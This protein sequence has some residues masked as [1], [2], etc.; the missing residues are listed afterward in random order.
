M[1]K[2]S[3]LATQ[4]ILKCCSIIAFIV[5]IYA[6]L[7][8]GQAMI[9]TDTSTSNRLFNSI[10]SSKSL[11]PDSWNYNNGEIIY[12]R[13]TLMPVIM[14]A[15]IPS[16]ILSRVVS[17]AIVLIIG[18]WGLIWIS[19][20][21]FNDYS[22]IVSIPVLLLFASS[23]NYRNMIF[24]ESAYTS[25]LFAF[26]FCFGMA[27]K[28]LINKENRIAYR[29]VH[30]ALLFL[31]MLCGIRSL[32]EYLLPLIVS[33]GT[34]Y[35]YQL[36]KHNRINV[37][38][39]NLIIYII[40]PA[41][42]GYACYKYVYINNEIHMY[43]TRASAID[44]SITGAEI[45]YNLKTTFINLFTIFGFGLKGNL[46]KNGLAIIIAI[47]V[48][49][50]FPVLQLIDYKKVKAEEMAYTLFAFIHNIIILIVVILSSKLY[51]RYLITCIF[52][53]T[54]ISA[55]YIYRHIFTRNNT[56]SLVLSILFLAV[57]IIY[58]VNLYSSTVG[59]KEKVEAQKE[60]CQK[61]IDKGITKVYAS[62][63]I[64][65]P[66][67]V[68][69]ENKLTAGA[70]TIKPRLLQKYYPLADDKA[71]EKKEGRSCILMTQAEAEKCHNA[72][73]VMCGTQTEDFLIKDAYVSDNGNFYYTDL[74]AYVFDEDVGEKLADGFRDG[75]LDIK[76]MD[77]NWYGTMT[78][79]T[80]ILEENGLIH[81][82]YSYLGKGHY[83]VKIEGKNLVGCN[84]AVISEISQE[85]ISFSTASVEDD[86]IELD[87]VLSTGIEDLQIYLSNTTPDTKVEF[88]D[89][90]VDKL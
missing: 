47:S 10:I 79:D 56:I 18:C 67:E 22:Y 61:L 75:L 29:V 1:N 27:Y 69:S 4:R 21:L 34:I 5:A 63:W 7:T 23:I 31:M 60:E 74:V 51:E 20:R 90:K 16:A 88:Y 58:G 80:I 38:I 87:L 57:T 25:Q 52:V 55:N 86:C 48:F 68:Y 85:S 13:E 65:Y 14:Q 59:W 71:F 72:V 36:K 49:I 77:F 46:L 8:I 41:I 3:E 73:F 83:S 15:L 66:H 39:K 53:A 26:T 24:Y 43:S 44:F 82:P 42:L 45:L 9:H 62:N 19:R 54:I 76:D 40:I 11:F 81:G 2:F 35:V 17:A 64:A 12:F 33:L 6:T 84:C 70:I 32:A 50:V 78:E 37:S 89:I 28:M 30:F